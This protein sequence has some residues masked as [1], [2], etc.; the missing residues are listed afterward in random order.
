M[1]KTMD[2]YK[3]QTFRRSVITKIADLRKE[4]TFSLIYAQVTSFCEGHHIDLSSTARQSRIKQNHS[5]LRTFLLLVL[6]I[7]EVI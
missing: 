3:A 5:Y 1:A 6:L 7:S 4:H 2:F